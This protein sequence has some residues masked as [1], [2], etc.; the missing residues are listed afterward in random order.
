MR[1]AA[2][3][4]Q[5]RPRAKAATLWDDLT[6]RCPKSIL[7]ELDVIEHDD[8]LHRRSSVRAQG[9]PITPRA[10]VRKDRGWSLGDR[11]RLTRRQVES[12]E[13]TVYIEIGMGGRNVADDDGVAGS[14]GDGSR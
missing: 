8:Y 2:F 12:G 3:V 7:H 14:A 1:I 4:C 13:P 5:P 10:T 6:K 9:P 11:S